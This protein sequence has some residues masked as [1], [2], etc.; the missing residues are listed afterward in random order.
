MQCDHQTS[1]HPNNRFTKKKGK[2]K[3]KEATW[4]RHR[5]VKVTMQTLYFK[6][7]CM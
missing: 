2:G 6:E 4:K 7:T 1:K 3:G 5:D